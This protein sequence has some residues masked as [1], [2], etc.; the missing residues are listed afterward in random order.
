MVYS[1]SVM[2]AKGC[3][4]RSWQETA[5]RL[6]GILP[7][8]LLL[9]SILWSHPASGPVLV[10]AMF[11]AVGEGIRFWVA[12][13][14]GGIPVDEREGLPLVTHGPH[15]LVRHPRY[16]GNFL[17]GLGLSI[18]ANW[19]IGY[20][21]YAAYCVFALRVLIPM[22]ECR[23]LQL[24]GEEY[25]RYQARTHLFVPNLRA[26]NFKGF[27]W[28]DAAASE[29]HMLFFLLS[30]GACFAVKWAFLAGAY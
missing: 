26:V 12:G 9:L 5:Y 14:L 11:L 8:P 15:G 25:R 22:E 30:I 3:V 2:R 16:V 23:L 27:I 21:L 24:H 20:G 19:W 13:Y 17:I 1:K 6:R 7:L 4:S 29:K 28:K 18:A 10:G